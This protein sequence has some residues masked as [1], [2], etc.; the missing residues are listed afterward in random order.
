MSG[1]LVSDS[2]TETD[3]EIGIHHHSDSETDTDEERVVLH[4]DTHVKLK[5]ISPE[6]LTPA[7]RSLHGKIRGFYEANDC[8]GWVSRKDVWPSIY[9]REEKQPLK[10]AFTWLAR[11]HGR[12][13]SQEEIDSHVGPGIWVYQENPGAEVWVCVK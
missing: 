2:E 1:L 10:G 4:V 11:K 6:G 13:S 7:K 5:Y 9:S 8:V 3:E 12:S